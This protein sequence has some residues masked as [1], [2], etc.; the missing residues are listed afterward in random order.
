M[1]WHFTPGTLLHYLDCSLRALHPLI[2][3]QHKWFQGALPVD[4]THHCDL[5]I[6]QTAGMILRTIILLVVHLQQRSKPMYRECCVQHTPV[7]LQLHSELNKVKTTVTLMKSVFM[8][9]KKKAWNGA[10]LTVGQNGQTELFRF[11]VDKHLII[12]DELSN[13]CCSLAQLSNNPVSWET[14]SLS[15]L[16]VPKALDCTFTAVSVCSWEFR[17]SSVSHSDFPAQNSSSS[18]A[19]FSLISSC[20]SRSG[21]SSSCLKG[22]A[23]LLNWPVVDNILALEQEVP[24]VS[25]WTETCPK[26][27]RC[28]WQA[29]K[30]LRL[31][32]QAW[33]ER[34]C[35]RRPHYSQK[36]HPDLASKEA[37]WGSRYVVWV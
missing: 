9:S 2:A 4:P 31:H 29:L 12:N 27:A 25:C 34:S 36:L 3:V 7:W 8:S 22:T 17:L 18:S 20:S 13:N 35:T 21:T 28:T 24:P 30:P 6:P 15:H 16:C 5:A 32:K 33:K 19:S 23:L 11:W 10:V 14:G 1:S 26:A 37:R